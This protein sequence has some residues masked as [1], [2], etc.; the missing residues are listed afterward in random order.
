MR[1]SLPESYAALEPK[2]IQNG[3]S[4]QDVSSRS[5][6]ESLCEPLR[7]TSKL[8][9]FKKLTKCGRLWPFRASGRTAAGSGIVCIC[10]V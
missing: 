7:R 3:E 5:P 4:H 9:I 1:Y 2:R 6:S 10:K 8:P